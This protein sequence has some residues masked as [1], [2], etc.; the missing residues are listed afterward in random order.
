MLGNQ[1]VGRA[2]HHQFSLG[3]LDSKAPE[4]VNNRAAFGAGTRG[5]VKDV[6]IPSLLSFIP[7][8]RAD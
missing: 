1:K 7:Q 4:T 3:N 8:A 6:Y 5:P 2:W